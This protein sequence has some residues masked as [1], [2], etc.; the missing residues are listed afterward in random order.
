MYYHVLVVHEIVTQH[1]YLL[2]TNLDTVCDEQVRPIVPFGM[3]Y[4]IF[5]NLIN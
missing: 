2:R 4:R 5:D 1:T 3:Y